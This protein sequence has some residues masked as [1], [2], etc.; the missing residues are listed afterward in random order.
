MFRSGKNHETKKISQNF[1]ESVQFSS[2]I[3]FSS[4][5][6]W[7]KSHFWHSPIRPVDLPPESSYLW[8][9]F[10]FY[11]A[12]E[13]DTFRGNSPKFP[14]VESKGGLFF[15]PFYPLGPSEAGGRAGGCLRPRRGVLI[16][17]ARHRGPAREKHESGVHRGAVFGPNRAPPRPWKGKARGLLST[18]RPQGRV[19][20]SETRSS[21]P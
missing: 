3:L 5:S 21:A 8:G 11:I 15:I 12:I 14:K 6:I 16:D 2:V 13:A 18:R 1:F 17:P 20:Q 9:S 4:N 19:R 7:R 10:L